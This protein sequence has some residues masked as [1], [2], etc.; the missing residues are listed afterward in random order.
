VDLPEK[1]E[2]IAQAK[3]ESWRELALIGPDTSDDNEAQCLADWPTEHI[4]RL[5]ICLMDAGPLESLTDLK[6]LH[7]SGNRIAT[8][9][10]RILACLTGLNSLD[11]S[12][13]QIGAEGALALASLTGLTWMSATC[14][15]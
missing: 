4:F 7:L 10:A 12:F 15:C 14:I 8:D 5:A 1:G 9:G 3:A 6:S 11:L 13:N 2:V